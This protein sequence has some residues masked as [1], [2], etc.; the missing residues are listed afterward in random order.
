MQKIILI[1][2]KKSKN[3]IHIELQYKKIWKN[4][5]FYESTN[6]IPMELL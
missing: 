5:D 1:I 2:M 3:L 6:S 4:D